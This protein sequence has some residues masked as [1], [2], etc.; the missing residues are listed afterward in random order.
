M[1]L[2]QAADYDA[3]SWEGGV[4]LLRHIS[5]ADAAE[6]GQ[7][8]PSFLSLLLFPLFF[9]PSPS[10]SLCV[11]VLGGRVDLSSFS[12]TPLREAHRDQL[13]FKAPKENLGSSK[14]TLG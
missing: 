3:D 14:S 7:R 13:S 1:P 6:Q 12:H 10:Q 5:Q 2:P 8:S 9:P 4:Q 11:S